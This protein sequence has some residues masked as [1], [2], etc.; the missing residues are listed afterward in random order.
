MPAAV[1][2][3]LQGAVLLIL[4]VLLIIR[5]IAGDESNAGRALTL[6]IVVL[7]FA[8]GAALVARALW[9]ASEG[10]RSPTLVWGVFVVLIGV[11]LARNGA[12]V[13][14]VVVVVVGAGT[15]AAG[16]VATGVRPD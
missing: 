2:M 8:L 11:T 3:G 5:T 12:P 1:L 6:A 7:V 15:L 10:A 13:M 16:W 4:G 14:G 9:Q